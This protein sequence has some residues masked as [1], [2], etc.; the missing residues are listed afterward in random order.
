MSYIRK[1]RMEYYEVVCKAKDDSA[2]IPDRS[3]DLNLWI[4]KAAKLSLEARTFDYY[5]EQARLD[6]FWYDDGSEFWFLNFV[7][8][9]E[10]NIPSKARKDKEAEPITL[11]D[12]EYIGEDVTALYD[13]KLNIFML[14]RNRHSLGVSGLE[15]YLNLIWNAEDIT[16]YLRPICPKNLQEKAKKRF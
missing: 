10:T 16:I 13:E 14:Q 5:E 2:G 15:E 1:V 9:R 8:L 12:D 11:D 3:F 4:N 7:R 6:K